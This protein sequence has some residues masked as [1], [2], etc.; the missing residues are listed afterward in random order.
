M[1]L[2]LKKRLDVILTERKLVES[3]TKAQ[4][5]I[6]NGFVYVNG[7]CI[8]KPSKRIN[9]NTKVLLTQ[10]F[11]YVGRGGI[12]L[13]AAIE[14]FS[15][16]VNEKTCLDLGASIGG[17]TDC[18][19]QK[20]AKKVYAVD[21]AKNM[22][23]PSLVCKKSKVIILDETDARKRFKLDELMDIIVIDITFASLKELI[24]NSKLYLKNDGDIIVL[25]KPLF[26]KK[27]E[28][29]EKLK[30]I[31]DKE[32][33]KIILRNLINWALLNEIYPINII[34]SPIL[35]KGGSIEFFIHFKLNKK[36]IIEKLADN[37]P[38]LINSLF[39]DNQ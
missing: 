22:L 16:N 25:V 30:I 10:E 39:Q 19:L 8:I 14:E 17:F 13:E 28:K 12:K 9:N 3:R 5:L 11:P 36:D 2:V 20:G 15:I 6:K 37:F 23:H 38:L 1:K 33:L 32:D 24:P 7:D 31:K 21:S 27:I 29:G 4:W 26:E 34:K 35:G 18:L